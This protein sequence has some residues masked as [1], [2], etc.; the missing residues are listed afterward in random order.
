MSDAPRPP[1]ARK[2]PKTIVQLG[3]T[4][5]DD[6]AWMKDDNWQKVLRDPAL[7][8]PDVKAHLTEENAYLKAM[9]ADTEG[10]QQ[11]IFEEMKG[12]IKEDDSSV[13]AKDSSRTREEPVRSS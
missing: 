13:P 4:R 11:A 6:Y 9:L 1:S 10:L 3:R 7:I 2:E 8:K 5:I 12:R